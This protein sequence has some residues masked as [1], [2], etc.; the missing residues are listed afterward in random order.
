M[1]SLISFFSSMRAE[2]CPDLPDGYVIN[3]YYLENCFACKRLGPVLEEIEDKLSKSNSNIKVRKVECTSCECGDITNFPTVVVTHDK[4]EMGKMVGYKNY[5]DLTH[6]LKKYLN[7]DEEIFKN[8][9]DHTEGKVK[10]LTAKDFLSGFDG[11]WMILFYNDN[12]DPRRALFLDLAMKYKNKIT[13][14]EINASESENV[15]ARFNISE[16]PYVMAMNHGN[17]LPYVGKIDMAS[18]SKFCDVLSK[19]AYGN[20]SFSE[21][22]SLSKDAKSGESI[23]VVLYKDFELSSYYF[24][25]LAQHFKFKAKIYRSNDPAMFA[26]AGKFPILK[27]TSP[28][29]E[30][31]D[32]SINK[33]LYLTVYKNGSFYSYTGSIENTNDVID[34]IFNTHFPHVTNIKNDNFYTVFHGIKPVV[35][36]LNN[37]N[38][39]MEKFERLSA[40]WHL[41]TATS[42]LIFASLNTTEYPMFKKQILSD[43]KEPS[44]LFYDPIKSTWYYKKVKLDI[45]NFSSESMKMIDLFLLGKLKSYPQ[46]PSN[47]GKYAIGTLIITSI[48]FCYKFLQNKK[49]VD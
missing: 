42:S 32:I 14:G 39:L 38:D 4:K 1:L 35:L 16:L 15:L 10:T 3:K 23:Y 45:N 26:S 48:L 8:H 34:W 49:K 6:E 41:G 13:F 47:Y 29:D 18:F 30:K 19:P 20:I 37:S 28:D 36:F 31:K 33:Q 40:N 11:Q 17:N 27:E 46:K 25:D 22:K 9:I 2:S 21:L 5:N 44:I 12:K 24:G 43:I 7:I